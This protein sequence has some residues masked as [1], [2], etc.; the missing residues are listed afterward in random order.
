M[1]QAEGSW[2]DPACQRGRP[3]SAVSASC[4]WRL[5]EAL[6]W[7]EERI[8]TLGEAVSDGGAPSGSGEEGPTFSGGDERRE[9]AREV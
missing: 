2:N 4:C 8:A 6:W 3:G 7:R 5:S 9:E 1:E